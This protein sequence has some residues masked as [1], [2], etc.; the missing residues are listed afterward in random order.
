MSISGSRP[1]GIAHQQRGVA[2][3]VALA[4]LLL[5]TMLAVSAA[6]HA[7]LQERM[8]GGLRNA[9]LAE[10]AAQTALRGAEWRLWKAAQAGQIRCGVAPIADCYVYDPARPSKH[11]QDFRSKEGWVT[12]GATEYKGGDGSQDYT[13]PTGSG[14]AEDARRTAALARNP[15]YLIED[16]GPEFAPGAGPPHEGDATSD[17]TTEPRPTGRHIYRITA[18]ATGGSEH[19]VRV[20]E[21]IFAA[22]GE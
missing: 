12:K 5:L 19:V 22:R 18:R 11:V 10:L 21:S 17:A 8:A 7:S 15:F 20:A 9:Q 6:G 16:L 3:M 4:F 2:L 14:L 13:M 1:R